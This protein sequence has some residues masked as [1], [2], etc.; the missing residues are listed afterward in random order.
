MN[1]RFNQAVLIFAIL[2][3]LA[4][5]YKRYTNKN[6]VERYETDKEDLLRRIKSDEELK[7]VLTMVSVSKL[8]TDQSVAQQAYDL[9]SSDKREE[10]VK[11]VESL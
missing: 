6:L 1:N 9:V 4:W 5:N 2:V 7:P 11:L 3:V 8:T 10:L